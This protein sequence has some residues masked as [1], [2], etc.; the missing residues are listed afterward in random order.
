[1]PRAGE[2]SYHRGHTEAGISVVRRVGRSF[3][4][5]ATVEP[6]TNR[7]K[8]ELAHRFLFSYNP[9]MATTQTLPE[10]KRIGETGQVSVGK[11]LAGKLVRVEPAPDGI[12]LRFVVDVAEKDVWWLHE[13]YKSKLKDALGWAR[14]NPPGETD[15]DALFALMKPSTKGDSPR[16][17]GS[18]KRV[19]RSKGARKR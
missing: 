18:A 13:P 2:G 6:R 4:V 1:M 8:V 9:T 12:M 19:S 10:V 11:S 14:K 15:L 3:N 17:A 7:L 16:T 5:A